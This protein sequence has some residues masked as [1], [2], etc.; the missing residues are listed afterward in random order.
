[1]ATMQAR[2]AELSRLQIAEFFSDNTSTTQEQCDRTAERILGRR[3]RPAPVQGSTSYTVVP[4]D[5]DGEVGE[6]GEV[7]ERVVQYRASD[8]ALDLDLLRCVEQTYG[9]FVPRHWDSGRLGKLH[10]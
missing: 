10:I 4:H 5:D 9:R 6:V 3:V 8:S 7:G 1:M 2:I